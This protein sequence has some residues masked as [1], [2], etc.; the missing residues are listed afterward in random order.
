MPVPERALALPSPRGQTW[1]MTR[2]R[3][4]QAHLPEKTIGGTFGRADGLP[5]ARR[6]E[7]ILDHRR[8]PACRALSPG[9]DRVTRATCTPAR[10][11]GAGSARARWPCLA[12]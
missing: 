2:Y 3:A 12:C 10:R 4:C 1:E 6:R 8:E 5:E 11:R 7:R 9:G